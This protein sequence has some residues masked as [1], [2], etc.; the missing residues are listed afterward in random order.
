MNDQQRYEELQMQN[1]QDAMKYKEAIWKKTGITLDDNDPSIV[2]FIVFHRWL[3]DFY[4]QQSELDNKNAQEVYTALSPMINDL[5]KTVAL[6]DEKD[7]TLKQ[8]ITTFQVFQKELLTLLTARSEELAKKNVSNEIKQQI[9][10][11]LDKLGETVSGSL[12]NLHTKNNY[13]LIG[14][15]ALQFVSVFL[16]LFMVLKL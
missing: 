6:I 16:L 5:T 12:K 13:L 4:S 3:E 9:S 2:M 15:F 10:G 1:T 11:S 7:K 14:V 8:D